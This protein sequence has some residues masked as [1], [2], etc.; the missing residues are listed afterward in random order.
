VVKGDIAVMKGDVTGLTEDMKV[1]KGDIAV[2]KGDIRRL[3]REQASL[4]G[5]QGLLTELFVQRR[6]AKQ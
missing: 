6:V 4:S 5:S 2:M 3:Y 1:V